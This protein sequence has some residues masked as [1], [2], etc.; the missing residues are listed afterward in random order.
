MLL[1]PGQGANGDKP[2]DYS[3]VNARLHEVFD[4]MGFIGSEK[5]ARLMWRAHLCHAECC[6]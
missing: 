2:M 4:A 1:F 5:V 3:T 6:C